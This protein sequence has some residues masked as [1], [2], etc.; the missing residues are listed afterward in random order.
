MYPT[1]TML[2]LEALL[3]ESTQ[4]E[5]LVLVDDGTGNLPGWSHPPEFAD[6]LVGF[7]SKMANLSCCCVTFNQ[8]DIDLMKEI[9]Q[10]VTEQVVTTRRSLWFHLDRAIPKPSDPGVPPIHYHQIVEPI[11]FDMPHF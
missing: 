8:M 7:V 5:R 3:A 2:I 4:L 10:R 6:F 1:T 11:S 9:T